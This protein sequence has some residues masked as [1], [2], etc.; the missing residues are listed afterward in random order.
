VHRSDD[1]VE[2]VAKRTAKYHAET[3]PIIPFYMSKGILKRVDGVGDPDRITERI[4]AVLE[5]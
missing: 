3:A 4:V 2:A 1:T 5:D